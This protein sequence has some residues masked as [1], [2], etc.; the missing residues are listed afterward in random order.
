MTR[1]LSRE[2][3]ARCRAVRPS[4][5]LEVRRKQERMRALVVECGRNIQTFVEDVGGAHICRESRIM[6]TLARPSVSERQTRPTDQ[7]A[8]TIRHVSGCHSG[9]QVVRQGCVDS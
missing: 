1:G 4:D 5:R 7:G 8:K 6:E 2:E 9:V 3:T